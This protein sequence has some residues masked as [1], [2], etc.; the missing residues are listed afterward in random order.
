MN[1]KEGGLVMDN[2]N[3]WKIGDFVDELNLTLDQK[4]H[5]NTINGWFKRLENNRIHYVNREEQTNEKVYDELDFKIALFIKKQ[6]EEK[7]A[8]S[9][10]E[11][12]LPN[13]FELRPFPIE[14]EK[15]NAPADSIDLIKKQL[16]EEIKKVFEEM[17]VTKIEEVKSQYQTLLNNLPKPISEEEKK[18][19]RFQT[20]I[21][22]RRIESKLQEEANQEWLKL[23]DS[24][25]LK[26][27]GLFRKDVDIEKKNEFI[28]NYVNRYFEECLKKEMGLDQ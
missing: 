2:G 28:R 26:K 8:L 23:P 4:L 13:H 20:M 16:T 25:R 3:F 15:F 14:E 19:Q 22:H 9:A 24:E 10:I 21:I 5:T 27:V 11:R 7:W 1:N 17:A 18:E 12:D 6:R